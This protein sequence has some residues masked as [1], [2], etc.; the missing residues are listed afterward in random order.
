MDDGRPLVFNGAVY[1]NTHSFNIDGINAPSGIK[2]L[3]NRYNIEAESKPVS[4]KSYQFRIFINAK[5]TLVLQELVLP[6]FCKSM[7]YKVGL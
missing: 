3:K 2:A 7:Y 4:G 5:N 6:Y 1:F